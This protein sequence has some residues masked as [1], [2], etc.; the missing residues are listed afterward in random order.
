MLDFMKQQ[1][2]SFLLTGHRIAGHTT[3]FV[4][5]VI[6]NCQNGDSTGGLDEITKTFSDTNLATSP[7]SSI[8]G[9]F[10]PRWKPH[11][12]VEKLILVQTKVLLS[13]L[14]FSTCIKQEEGDTIIVLKTMF[15]KIALI[16]DPSLFKIA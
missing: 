11:C 9:G 13:T 12:T 5:Q 4:N 14:Y 3:E 2:F 16:H 7:T 15:G 1:F 10:S 8:S 6:E